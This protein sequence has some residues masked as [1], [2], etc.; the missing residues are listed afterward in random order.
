MVHFM[1]VNKVVDILYLVEYGVDIQPYYDSLI[2]LATKDKHMNVV[3]YLKSL[4]LSQ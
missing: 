4:N 2:E 1:M 3:E